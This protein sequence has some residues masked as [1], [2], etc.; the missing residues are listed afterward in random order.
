[1]EQ[2]QKAGG[3]GR[4]GRVVRVVIKGFVP[5]VVLA[6]ALLGAQ[7]MMETTPE[8]PRRPQERLAKLVEVRTFETSTSPVMIDTAMGVVMPARSLEI[9]PQVSGRIEWIA[10][11]L[12]PGAVIEAGTTL[13]RIER[14][15][16]E[17]AV[18]EQRAAILSAEAAE[19]TAQ[20]SVIAAEN[21]L[22]LEMGNQTVSQREY[23]L[24]GESIDEAS[25]HL[26]LRVPQLRS[27]EAAVKSAEAAVE[28]A[29]A[30]KEAAKTRLAQAELDLE[31][32][33]ITAPYNVVVAAKL[34]DVGD[35]VGSTTAVLTL[36]GTDEFW[37]ELAI[38]TSLL[39][40]VEAGVSPVTLRSPAAWG[41]GQSREGRVIR[42]LPGV[43]SGGR[44]ARVLVSVLDPLV[45]S[46]EHA[47]GPALLVNDYL[48]ATIEGRAIEGVIALPRSLVREG[49]TVW[50]MND[51]DELEIRPI[52]TVYRGREHV[53]VTSGLA[54]GERVVTT[55]IAAPVSGMPL[56]QNAGEG[57]AP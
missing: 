9:K 1:M 7:R 45:Q 4:V 3:V 35:V 38:P 52:Q 15:D 31:R 6:G 2:Q 40:W 57:G 27:A 55:D 56:R 19:A 5:L 34:A 43:D 16:F 20:A 28:S 21:D 12:E 51:R 49:D 30:A 42:V 50:V 33:E 47:E 14:A 41:S 37:I 36:Y 54:D 53:L 39:R 11:G 32:T 44:M 26:V 10:P 48:S 22:A 23:E 8:T 13:M 18:A 29:R 17:L 25:Q 46:P 24:L